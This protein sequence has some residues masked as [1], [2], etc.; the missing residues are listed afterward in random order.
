MTLPEKL[1]DILSFHSFFFFMQSMISKQ[2]K[3]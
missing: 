2:V 3:I 1:T